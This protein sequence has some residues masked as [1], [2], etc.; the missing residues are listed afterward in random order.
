MTVL[1]DGKLGLVVIKEETVLEF[2]EGIGNGVVGSDGSE[3]EIV[4]FE[5]VSKG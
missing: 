2:G 5:D 1:G 4:F 3:G